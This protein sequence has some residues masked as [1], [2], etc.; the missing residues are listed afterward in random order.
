MVVCFK[1]KCVY[2]KFCCCCLVTKSCPTLLRPHGGSPG[3]SVHWISQAKILEWVVISFSRGSSQRRDWTCVS[4]VFHT[5]GAF[6]TCWATVTPKERVNSH[7]YR[8]W[9]DFS[10]NKVH[11]LC[12][13]VMLLLSHRCFCSLVLFKINEI[14]GHLFSK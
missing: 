14:A 1:L 12:N 3:S 4:C 5:A 2:R 8:N 13:H 7:Y 6:F 10:K 11:G 9:E